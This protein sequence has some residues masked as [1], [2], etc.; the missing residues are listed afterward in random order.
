MLTKLVGL[1]ACHEL[2]AR[3]NAPQR[4]RSGSVSCSKAELS[5]LSDG[6]LSMTV[7]LLV[8]THGG[9][10]VIHLIACTKGSR[11]I[12]CRHTQL[13]LPCCW[14]CRWQRLLGLAAMDLQTPPDCVF[15]HQLLPSALSLRSAMKL[16]QSR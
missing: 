14:A 3:F 12:R 6:R 16:Q 5:P 8:H 15:A 4:R 7:C 10:R 11:S 1:Q 13:Q 9:P 2:M